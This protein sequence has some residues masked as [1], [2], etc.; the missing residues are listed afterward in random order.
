MVNIPFVSEDFQRAFRNQFPSQTST[1]RDLHVSDVVIPVV[2]FTPTSSGASLP[3]ELRDTYN[4]SAEFANYSDTQ[5]GVEV[6]GTPGFW[7]FRYNLSYSDGTYQP[8]IKLN[9]K[10]TSTG[11]SVKFYQ[12]EFMNPTRFG[13]LSDDIKI[14]LPV[15]KTITLDLSSNGSGTVNYASSVYQLAD[16]NGNLTNPSGYNPQ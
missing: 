4:P 3:F 6:I 7:A 9:F 16:V 14:F 13:D 2:D 15:G 1:G 10:T 11:V 8:S 5:T 12:K